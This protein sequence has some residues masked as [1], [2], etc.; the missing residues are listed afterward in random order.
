M[1]LNEVIRGDTKKWSIALVDDQGAAFDLTGCTVWFTAKTAISNVADDAD[2]VISHKIVIDG[3]GV[4]T[5]ADGFAIGGIHP[6]TGNP[7]SGAASGVLTQT[8]S[9][10]DSTALS[11]GTYVYDLQVKDSNGEVYTPILGMSLTVIEDVTR[12]TT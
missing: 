10:A 4:A 8:L 5:S 12:S 11:A 1:A 9:A 3:S 6:T 2:A 7:A